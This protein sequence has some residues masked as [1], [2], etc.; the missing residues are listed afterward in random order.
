MLEQERIIG[1]RNRELAARIQELKNAN[2]LAEKLKFELARY[3]RWRFGKKSE[4]LGSEQIALWE[5]ELDADIEALHKRLDDLKAGL[6][7]D[8][9]DQDKKSDKKSAHKRK[10]KREAL[11]DSLPRVDVRLEPVSTTCECGTP[12]IR[13][14]EDAA[15]SLQMIPSRFWV[16]RTIRGKIGRAHV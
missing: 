7:D 2:A 10:P 16:K 11:P 14:G 6:R 9:P 3:Q 12:M 4:A 5:A 13:I 15:E 1:E 8:D